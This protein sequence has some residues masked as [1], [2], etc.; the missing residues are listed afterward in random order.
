MR[1]RT[2][3]SAHPARLT[4]FLLASLAALALSAAAVSAQ[5]NCSGVPPGGPCTGVVDP[6]PKDCFAPRCIEN[7]CDL[8]YPL[9]TRPATSCSTSCR[10]PGSSTS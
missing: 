1:L 2:V 4:A 5:S 8:N 7:H 10:S 6:N 9:P 3:R